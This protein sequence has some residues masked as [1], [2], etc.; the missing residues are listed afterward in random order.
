MTLIFDLHTHTR[1]SRSPV[2]HHA[3][4]TVLEN[5]RA[6]EKLKIGL[7]IAEHG[8]G[9]ALF[10]VRVK[11][12]PRL[13][14]DID[15]ANRAL[16][17][18]LVLLGIEANLMAADGRTDYDLLPI[19]PDFCLMGYHKGVKNQGK[20]GRRLLFPA[21]FTPDK[22]KVRMTDAIIKALS[23]YPIDVL[24]HPGEYVPIDLAAVAR[25]AAELGVVLELN[26]KHPMKAEEIDIA[27][28]NGAHFILSSDAHVPENVGVVVNALAEAKNAKIPKE[29]IVNSGAYGFD[30]NLRIDK[31]GDWAKEVGQLFHRTNLSSV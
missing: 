30:H 22:C 1:Y 17:K 23:K 24:T 12:Y 10:G 8:P 18:K 9:H 11:E 2:H 16:N 5:A 4:G 21:L 26:N 31:L 29:F 13:R 3:K 7:G 19:K 14:A 20:E 15:E 25:A 28:S 27:L 6:A